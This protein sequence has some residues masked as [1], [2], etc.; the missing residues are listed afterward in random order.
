MT[1]T[2]Y[3]AR[4]QAFIQSG[5][6][7]PWDKTHY[8]ACLFTIQENVQDE[9]FRENILIPN[10]AD[11]ELRWE[12]E[13][14]DN[15]LVSW[16]LPVWFD[17]THYSNPLLNMI[18]YFTALY[19]EPLRIGTHYLWIKGNLE[20]AIFRETVPKPPYGTED[21]PVIMYSDNAYYLPQ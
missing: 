12:P 17:F 6:L 16:K 20:I 5:K 4:K 9:I 7:K 2:E 8:S 19:G 21:V 3:Q 11:V 14:I 10:S 13:F 15:K 1:Q 18:N